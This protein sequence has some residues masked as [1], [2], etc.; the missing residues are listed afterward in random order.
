MLSIIVADASLELVPK[1]M[2][3]FQPI[4]MM[5]KSRGK[6]PKEIV[7]DISS[8]LPLK[9]VI[10]PDQ[11]K[12]GR[13]DVVHRVLLAILDSPLKLSFPMKLYLHTYEGRIFEV[14]PATR[15]PRN[16]LRFLGLM[17]QL[18]I[19]GSVGP[20]DKPLIKETNLDL[21]S[22]I[23]ILSPKRKIALSDRGKLEDPIKVAKEALNQDTVIIVGGFPHGDYSE[24]VREIIDEKISLCEEVIS[25]SAAIC[26]LLSYLFYALR[27]SP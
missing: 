25:A 18:L 5:A 2:A 11:E 21:K 9:E 14:D 20:R 13:P 10:I 22:L 7:F 16:Y 17:E 12:R 6:K 3:S 1:R 26:M 23:K 8:L 24:K 15:L 4:K 27:W 19:K